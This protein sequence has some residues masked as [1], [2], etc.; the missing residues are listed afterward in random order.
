MRSRRVGAVFA[1]LALASGAAACGSNSSSGSS[2]NAS[3][4]GTSAAANASANC[5]KKTIRVAVFLASAANTYWEA[6]LQG[7]KDVAAKCPNVKLTAFDG[8]F[9]TNTQVNQLRDALVS[10]RY[11]AWFVGPNDGGPLTATIK[12]AVKQGVKVGCA[13][14]PCGPDIRDVHVQIPGQVIF[15]GLGFYPNGQQLGQLVVQGCK[16][17]SS[18]KVLWLPG[19]PTL[20]L[21]KA[22]QDGLY[23]VIKSHP[24]IHVVSIRGGGYLAAPALTATQNVLRAH[25]DL[26]VIVSSGDQM[27]AGSARAARIAGKQGKIKMYG[28]GCTVEAKQLIEQGVQTGCSVYLPRTEG[29]L[30]V[31]ALVNAV[32]GSKKT[33]IYV[34]PLKY[35]N[36]GGLGTKAN[37]A[38]FK[39]EF[40]S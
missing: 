22:R 37:I 11:Q 39:P 6:A 13:L 4:G 5:G 7:A 24:N 34:N 23:S 2:G 25:P 16:G 12:Q 32:N 10:K 29:R 20:P 27:I 14:V 30:V 35:S 9:T 38:K 40:H 28:N 18:C 33:G 21:E 17:I 26:N 19:L 8:K 15:A 31:S 1:A 3:G 36:I